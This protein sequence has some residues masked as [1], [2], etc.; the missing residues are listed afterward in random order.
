MTRQNLVGLVLA[1][2]A[3]QA[4]ASMHQD[5]LTF[6]RGPAPSLENQAT[7]QAGRKLQQT[8]DEPPQPFTFDGFG[9]GTGGWFPGGGL[10][11]G[12]ATNIYN[13]VFRD[14]F[15]TGLTEYVA[16]ALPN[17]LGNPLNFIPPEVA[18][19]PVGTRLGRDV[20]SVFGFDWFDRYIRQ[21]YTFASA[22]RATWSMQD[23]CLEVNGGE[24]E[25]KDDGSVECANPSIMLKGSPLTCNLPYRQAASLETFAC[26]ARGRRL[27]VSATFGTARDGVL[28]PPASLYNFGANVNITN[29]NLGFN[30]QL[31]RIAND[32]GVQQWWQFTGQ[33]IINELFRI[34]AALVSGEVDRRIY[35]AELEDRAAALAAAAEP[36]A[37]PAGASGVAA[38]VEALRSAGSMLMQRVAQHMG[39]SV[40][41]L[42]DGLRAAGV[43]AA[44]ATATATAQQQQQQQQQAPVQAVFATPAT[45]I[46][47]TQDLSPLVTFTNGPDAAAPDAVTAAA[48]PRAAQVAPDAPA[49]S[50]VISQVM[51]ESEGDAAMLAQLNQGLAA[52][53]A[54]AGRTAAQQQMKQAEPVG[55]IAPV[56]PV[57][58]V[59]E[60]K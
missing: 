47:P 28:G 50:M 54:T 52:D 24:C 19:F 21:Y 11:D 51:N 25:I 44:A 43:P 58:P 53:R 16:R 41:D 17:D 5:V 2:L 33:L 57:A 26:A 48:A 35:T 1:T 22:S 27:A 59:V 37:G 10:F 34:Q 3:L 42:I 30:A 14:I 7:A 4:A 9:F 39:L 56:A 55:S 32:F 13:I 8:F 45:A 46:A 18:G 12:F 49:S 20:V 15:N 6:L 29:P 60:P 23:A 38:G 36:V 40:A 31:N